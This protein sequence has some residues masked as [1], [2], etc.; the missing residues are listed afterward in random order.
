MVVRGESDKIS[1]HNACICRIGI[2]LTTNKQAPSHPFFS[3]CTCP[4]TRV[5]AHSHTQTPWGHL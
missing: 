5:C 4:H 2:S 3:L 1:A